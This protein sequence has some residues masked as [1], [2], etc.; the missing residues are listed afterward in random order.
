VLRCDEGDFDP[1]TG[2]CAAPYWETDSGPLPPLSGAEGMQIAAAVA[3]VW[4]LGFI[5]KQLRRVAEKN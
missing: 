5:V 1:A 4:F 3:S 2:Q